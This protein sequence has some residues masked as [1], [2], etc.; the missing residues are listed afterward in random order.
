MS[1][2]FRTRVYISE[3]LKLQKKRLFVKYKK[4]NQFQDCAHITLP[5]WNSA[6]LEIYPY[7]ELLSDIHEGKIS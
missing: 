6:F 5:L 3:I 2:S 4:R 7:N 1:E